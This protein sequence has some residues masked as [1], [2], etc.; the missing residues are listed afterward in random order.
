MS[1]ETDQKFKEIYEAE[2]KTLKKDK[3]GLRITSEKD[4]EISSRLQKKGFPIVS[5]TGGQ[6]GEI[7]TH[8]FDGDKKAI[9]EAI[10]K[11]KKDLEA[12]K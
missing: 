7:K 4:Y 9:E 6:I 1:K 3:F 11:I 12:G 2:K 8:W 10:T 5:I